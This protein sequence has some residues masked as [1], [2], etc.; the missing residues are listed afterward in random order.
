MTVARAG[1]SE[2]KN[3][4]DRIATQAGG[5]GLSVLIRGDDD[6]P[7]RGAGEGLGSHGQLRSHCLE[8][9]IL[10]ATMDARRPVDPPQPTGLFA[11]DY[12]RYSCRKKA[13]RVTDRAGGY[14]SNSLTSVNQVSVSSRPHPR[15][16]CPCFRST[17]MLVAG[18]SEHRGSE[19]RASS[20]I[21]IGR[22]G[23]RYSICA[24]I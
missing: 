3:R 15:H 14:P 2:K 18:S 23:R 11:S 9:E 21:G 12:R 24:L 5:G 1:S 6:R 16:L 8:I 20:A 13:V 10:V 7:L 17:L 19:F 4:C 22:A